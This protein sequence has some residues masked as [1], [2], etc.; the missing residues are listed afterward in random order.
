MV[1]YFGGRLTFQIVGITPIA[2]AVPDNKQNVIYHNGKRCDLRGMPH[3]SYEHWWLEGPN[4]EVREM[5]EPS[6]VIRKYSKN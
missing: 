1:P 3:V 5:I 4:A 6:C 2:D